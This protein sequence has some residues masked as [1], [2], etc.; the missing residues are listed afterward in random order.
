MRRTVCTVLAA[1]LA[2][3]FSRADEVTTSATDSTFVAEAV[4]RGRSTAIQRFARELKSGD[5]KERVAA[6]RAL[7]QFPGTDIEPLLADFIEL[8]KED[9]LELTRVTPLLVAIGRPAAAPLVRL[10]KDDD[11]YVA[12][13]ARTVLCEM[14]PAAFPELADALRD[15]RAGVRRRACA[16]THC[17]ATRHRPARD[18]ETTAAL[19]PALAP[20]TRDA[21]IE[22]RQSALLTFCYLGAA[23]RPEL[24]LG[25]RDPN[26]D[27][28]RI[29]C[30]TIGDL[31]KQAPHC[32]VLP[33]HERLQ[34][35]DPLVRLEALDALWNIAPTTTQPIPVLLEGLW[36]E[37]G[38]VRLE[39]LVV[40]WSMR[41]EARDELRFLTVPLTHLL[42]FDPN[43]RVRRLAARLLRQIQDEARQ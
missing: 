32:V 31:G 10:L 23:D 22:V 19:L 25:L 18:S 9:G 39:A 20:L 14:G 37:R 28:R 35:P 6:A 8:L 33:L 16:V 17:L 21:Q 3:S 30:R 43:R 29:L 27:L 2:I 41:N 42:W 40:V 13:R 7:A 36:H 15:S 26:A 1:Y 11:E 5:E 12:E 38:D 4:A 34:D 24:L